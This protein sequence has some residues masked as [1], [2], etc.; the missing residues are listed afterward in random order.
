MN[1][2]TLSDEL[3]RFIHSIAS[4]PQL[5]AILLLHQ[6]QEQV[7]EKN[8]LAQG[9]YLNKEQA[10]A[11]LIDLH[12]A[13]ICA[14][15]PNTNDGFIYSPISSELGQLIDQL[16]SYYARNLIE[17]TNMIHSTATTGQRIQQFADAFKF[18]KD[19]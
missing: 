10:A 16:A 11:M 12:A 14:P 3:R 15:A 18:F 9:L 7:W 4:I 13:G 1:S 6:A 5:E 8:T 2:S 19:K 17:V